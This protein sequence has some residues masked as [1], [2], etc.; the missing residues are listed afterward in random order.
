MIRRRD[1]L[2][3]IYDYFKTEIENFNHENQKG[4]LDD[5]V[6]VILEINK[7]VNKVIKSQPKVGEWIP[8]SENMEDMPTEKDGEYVLVSFS[9]YSLPDI[10]RYQEDEDGGAFYPGDEDYTYTSVG[11]FVNAWQPLPDPYREDGGVDAKQM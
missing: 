4:M 1:L 7:G 6:D 11:L 9:N 2:D 5:L 8:C 3:D 10:G